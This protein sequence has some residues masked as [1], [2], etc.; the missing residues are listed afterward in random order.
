[1]R[2]KQSSQGR[3]AA[4]ARPVR[5]GTPILTRIRREQGN[6]DPE[7]GARARVGPGRPELFARDK[8]S[9]REQP[10]CRNP[11]EQRSS[12]PPLI[13]LAVLALAFFPY[14]F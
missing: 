7:R 2:G 4:R 14:R 8:D 3:S 13:A 11:P 9:Y 6:R 12:T 10:T 1:M 5:T